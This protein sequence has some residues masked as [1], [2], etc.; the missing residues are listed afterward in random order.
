MKGSRT[1]WKIDVNGWG[2]LYGY[3]TEAQAEKFRYHKSNW[4][5]SVGR[6]T[7][8]KKEEKPFGPTWEDLSE[9]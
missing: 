7:K 3:G 9:F 2:T 5:C 8:I 1:Y 4:E 6:K